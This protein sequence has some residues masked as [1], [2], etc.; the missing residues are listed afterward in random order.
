MGDP[1]DP[2]RYLAYLLR[3][4][5]EQ[6]GGSGTA[7][8]RFSLEDAHSNHRWGFASIEEMVRFLR[9]QLRYQ[10]GEDKG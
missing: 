5:K 4:W 3:C 8:W 7:A 2:P 10:D 1:N 6:R 9:R